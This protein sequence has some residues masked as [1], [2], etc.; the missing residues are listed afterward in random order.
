[1]L[2][3]VTAATEVTQAATQPATDL[4]TAVTMPVWQR[5]NWAPA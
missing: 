2:P 1:M 3:S 5:R 4:V